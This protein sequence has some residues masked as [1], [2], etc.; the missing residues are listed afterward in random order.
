MK[1]WHTRSV[2]VKTDPQRV[3]FMNTIDLLAILQKSL[4]RTL[5]HN[6][7]EYN[8]LYLDCPDPFRYGEKS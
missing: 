4:D 8:R 3:R 6:T 5:F 1:R 7:I 2:L